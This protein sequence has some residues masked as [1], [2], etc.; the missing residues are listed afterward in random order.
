MC[1]YSYFI[2]SRKTLNARNNNNKGIDIIPISKK[3]DKLFET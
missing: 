2:G 3:L 1:P